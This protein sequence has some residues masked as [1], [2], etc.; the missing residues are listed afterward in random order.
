VLLSFNVLSNCILQE[1]FKSLK[2][3]IKELKERGPKN[4]VIAI[5][6]NKNDLEDEREVTTSGQQ[7]RF[8]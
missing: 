3:W 4:I 8:H 7:G 6:G 1:T 5:A 2:S